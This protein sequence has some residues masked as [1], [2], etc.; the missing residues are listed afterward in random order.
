VTGP[1]EE[2]ATVHLAFPP[3]PRLLGMVRLVVGVVA[4]QAGVDDEGVEDLKVAVSETCAVAVNETARAGLSALIELDLLQDPGG[5]R[6]GVEVRDRAPEPSPNSRRALPSD[7]ALE[8]DDRQ[9]GLALVGALV[10]DLKSE[11]LEGGGHRISFWLYH[12]ALGDDDGDAGGDG[13][14]S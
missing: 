10:T 9:F 14:A 8:L 11:P 3:E 12:D 6:F 2:L 4:R 5:G 1:D 13:P 7:E